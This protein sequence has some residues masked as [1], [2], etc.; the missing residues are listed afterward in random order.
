MTA[1][2]MP[3]RLISVF[4]LLALADCA[5]GT[6]SADLSPATPEPAPQVAAVQPAPQAP[7]PP[8]PAPAGR[9]TQVAP[10]TPPPPARQAALT[11]EEIKGQCW[12]KYENDRRVKNIDERLKLV[13]KCV[14]DTSRNQPKPPAER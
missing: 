12:M 10:P 2:R 5:G 14:D 1:F 9:A 8:P 3:C 7:P 13:E 4:A 11:P 6:S